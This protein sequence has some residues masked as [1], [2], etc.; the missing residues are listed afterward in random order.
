MKKSNFIVLSLLALIFLGACSKNKD[1]NEPEPTPTEPKKDSV[2]V[3]TAAKSALAP[4][5]A[6]YTSNTLD[7]GILITEGTGIE[8]TGTYHNYIVNN[9][10]FFSL[11]FGQA[12]PGAVS[13]F[14][15]GTDKSLTALQ[16]F[17]TE[18]MTAFT[19]AG[20]DLLLIKNAWQPEEQYTKWYRVDTKTLQI[21]AQGEI[22]A[23]ALTGKGE[24]AF[25]TDVKLVGDKVFAPFWPV[26]SGRNFATNYSQDSTYIAVYSYPN[27]TLEKVI[28][29]SRTGGIGA[30]YTSGIEVDEKGDTYVLGTKLNWNKS[31][32]YSTATPVAF[33]KIK[34]GTTEYDKSYFFNITDVS[35]GQYV[36][37]KLYLGKGYFLLT[38]CP[39]PFVYATV[40]YGAMIYGGIKF[41]VVNVYDGSFKWVTG[42]PAPTKITTTSG[43]APSYSPLNG[44][45][46]VPIYYTDT[47]NKARSVVFKFDA[48]T[49]TATPGL[50]TDGKAAI[51][52]ICMLPV[53]E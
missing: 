38:M 40:M 7:S 31:S 8:Q 24:K 47:D 53:T 46:Y 25:F 21:V 15:A 23:V 51:T 44:T 17:Q 50:E 2:F 48:A 27:M 20:D 18:T 28:T 29:D 13:V 30:Y 33:T 49:A 3:L 37:S 41:A 43:Y 4:V 12:N 35:G 39:N 32:K 9:G 5:D 11:M 52:S 36:Y 19:K 10:K 6:I 34:S 45:G 16:S 26:E 14:K 42:A 1:H 22:D